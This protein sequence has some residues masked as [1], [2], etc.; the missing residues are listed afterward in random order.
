MRWVVLLFLSYASA[1]PSP[2]EG[3]E[4][5]LLSSDGTYLVVTSLGPKL[6]S[7]E[8]AKGRQKFEFVRSKGDL[9]YLRFGDVLLTAYDDDG[10]PEPLFRLYTRPTDGKIALLVPGQGTGLRASSFTVAQG[11][12]SSNDE[13]LWWTLMPASKE[14]EES[15]AQQPQL[16]PPGGKGKP[17]LAVAARPKPTSV[18]LAP[19]ATTTR[20]V[21]T[22]S[23]ALILAATA[24]MLP[25]GSFAVMPSMAPQL[26]DIL[27]QLQGLIP[28]R[29]MSA[30]SI[31]GQGLRSIGGLV[32]GL[33]LQQPLAAILFH[34]LLTDGVSDALAQALSHEAARADGT[35][36]GSLVLDWPRL[37]RS[38]WVAFV[39]DDL[40]FMLWAKLLWDGFEKLKPL[41]ASSTVLPP[42]LAAFLASPVGIAGLK[43]LATQLGYESASTA[44]YLG[45]QEAARG[46]GGRGVLREL[47]QKFWKA[48]TSGVAFFSATHLL[49]FLVPL[50]WLQPILDNLSCLAFNTYL[51]MLSHAEEE[52]TVED[53]AVDGSDAA[54]GRV[55]GG[56]SPATSSAMPLFLQAPRASS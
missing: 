27:S 47:K 43:T 5:A 11:E 55:D 34:G 15:C 8:S 53:S 35:G 50:W 25:A 24:A 54:R 12:W 10:T 51:A 52:G 2:R 39:S 14:A 49:M 48:W 23:G 40:P 28:L 4:Y 46:G 3:I 16:D 19:H 26:A 1:F 20:R 45:L 29:V 37:R 31:L 38:S 36:S 7:A 22:A 56:Q 32:R 42:W 6:L 44:T 21:A 17:R 33:T 30:A 13:A 9:V 41:I 18:R